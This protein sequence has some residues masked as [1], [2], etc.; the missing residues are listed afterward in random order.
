MFMYIPFQST[1][2]IAAS[3][4]EYPDDHPSQCQLDVHGV[5]DQRTGVFLFFICLL[6]ITIFFVLALKLYSV[7]DKPRGIR[8]S[9]VGLSMGSLGLR[10]D[11]A[12]ETE[13]A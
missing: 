12:R 10:E 1:I 6:Y 3:V 8:R 5:N 9:V 7:S 11:Y 4:E 2:A 13:F